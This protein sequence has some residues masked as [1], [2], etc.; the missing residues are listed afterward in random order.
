VSYYREIGEDMVWA[1]GSQSNAPN[2]EGPYTLASGDGQVF[3][4]DKVH[5]YLENK[6]WAAL[7]EMGMRYYVPSEQQW[8]IFGTNQSVR[9]WYEA[10]LKKVEAM[11]QRIKPP[12]AEPTEQLTLF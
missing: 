12:Q 4:A 1:G 9:D 8:F 7:G 11:R 2:I 5:L 6:N 10:W 3:D